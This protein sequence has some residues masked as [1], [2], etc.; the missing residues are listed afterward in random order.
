MCVRDVDFTY[1]YDFPIECWN[2]SDSGLLF[3]HFIIGYEL[4]LLK[5]RVAIRLPYIAS[6]WSLQLIFHM[7]SH[8]PTCEKQFPSVV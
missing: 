4:Q 7:R 8:T 1:F 2:C 5:K 3:F 6:Q